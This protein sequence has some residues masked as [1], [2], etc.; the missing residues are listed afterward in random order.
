MNVNNYYMVIYVDVETEELIKVVYV[1][2]QNIPIVL[3]MLNMEASETV[4]KLDE[5][6]YTV[7][8]KYFAP[9]TS[10]ATY[11]ALVVEVEEL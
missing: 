5:I 9:A 3:A 1:P 7:A 10:K 2:V 4:I 6:C 8:S 11:N